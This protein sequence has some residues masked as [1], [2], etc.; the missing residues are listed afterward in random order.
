MKPENIVISS[1]GHFKLTDFGISEIG[2]LHNKYVITNK[3][4]PESENT[5]EDKWVDSG[6]ILGTQ[7]Y[8][9]PEVIKCGKITYKTDYWSVGVILYELFANQ[10]PFYNGNLEETFE[11]ILNLRID[12]ETFDKEV[13]DGK[14]REIAKDL[15]SKFLVLDP[16]KRWGDIN[17]EEVKAHKFFK[18]F[19]WANV[20]TMKN[21]L[22]LKHVSVRIK[23]SKQIKI[24]ASSPLNKINEEDENKNSNKFANKDENKGK[25]SS[26]N[27]EQKSSQRNSDNKDNENV[28]SNNSNKHK[29]DF[30]LFYSER[31]DNLNKKNQDVLKTNIK[32]KKI[33]IDTDDHNFT[34]LMH[35][36][37]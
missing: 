24:I 23:Q 16:L 2:L 13:E 9:A 29:D 8:M 25:N 31:I 7:N 34:N 15:I 37:D 27:I 33:E 19:D 5:E 6:K 21:L 18:N 10:T 11:N 36:L 20:K 4:N 3:I 1:N 26:G 22:V 28:N 35:D 14:V 32:L 12:W 30:N 17:I